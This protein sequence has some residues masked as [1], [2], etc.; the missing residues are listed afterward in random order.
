M[1]GGP[2][3]HQNVFS[4]SVTEKKH[5]LASDESAESAVSALKSRKNTI[6]DENR[7]KPGAI[8]DS[9]IGQGVPPPTPPDQIDQ[10]TPETGLE[11]ISER[12]NVQEATF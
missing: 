6:F 5:G 11:S 10:P 8:L 2:L 4:V 1:Q 9:L 12:K 3:D 7:P